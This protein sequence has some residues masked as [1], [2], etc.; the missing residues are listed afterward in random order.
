MLKIRLLYGRTPVRFGPSSLSSMRVASRPPLSR[1]FAAVPLAGFKGKTLLPGLKMIRPMLRRARPWFFVEYAISHCSQ[2]EAA[3]IVLRRS[4]KGRRAASE[5]YA[6]GGRL[7]VLHQ[8]AGRIPLS[9]KR[10]DA[11][12]CH[13]LV[14]AGMESCLQNRNRHR[15]LAMEHPWHDYPPDDY[16]PPSRGHSTPDHL[17]KILSRGLKLSRPVRTYRQVLTRIERRHA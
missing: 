14:R 13:S 7:R 16:L 15:V 10:A 6:D 17:S 9:T 8:L 11:L 4:A 12:V 3:T 5:F 2:K 1:E